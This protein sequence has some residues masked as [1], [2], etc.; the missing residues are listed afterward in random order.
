LR[1]ALLV[2]LALTA[3]SAPAATLKPTTEAT[4]TLDERIA[5]YVERWEGN[6]GQYGIILTLD[7]CENLGRLGLASQETLDRLDDEGPA[8]PEWRAANGYLGAILERVEEIDC[9]ESIPVP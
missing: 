7:D 3:C 2:A 8:N 4:P 1:Y 6:E 9:P 5:G